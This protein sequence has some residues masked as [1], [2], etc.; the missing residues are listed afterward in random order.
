MELEKGKADETADKDSSHFS[1]LLVIIMHLLC[2]MCRLQKVMIKAE[3]HSFK[4][5]VYKLVHMKPCGT[6][7][8]TPIYL[9]VLHF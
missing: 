6:K 4:E 9:G 7:G 5:A 1:R 8:F 3:E 2:L